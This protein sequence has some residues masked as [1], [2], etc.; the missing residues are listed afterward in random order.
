VLLE[1]GADRE[2]K[3]NVSGDREGESGD[4]S[5]KGWEQEETRVE[6]RELGLAG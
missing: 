1:A 4:G 5:G 6:G 2:A 3:D